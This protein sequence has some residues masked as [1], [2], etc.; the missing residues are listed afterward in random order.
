[1]AMKGDLRVA[2]FTFR[3]ARLQD[4]LAPALAVLC[5]AWS[6][7]VAN[8]YPPWLAAY[9]D[10]LSALGLILLCAAVIQKSASLAIPAISWGCFALAAVPLLQVAFGQVLFFGDGYI[11]FLY[12]LCL[13]T[14]IVVGCNAKKVWRDDFVTFICAAWLFVALLSC[15]ILLMQRFS[16][17]AGDFG[18]FIRDVR[19][20]SAP[21]GN[22]GQPNQ[23]ATFF[24]L[25]LVALTCL[26]ERR[27]VGGRWAMVAAVLIVVCMAMTQSR[28]A[29]L[30]LL[31]LLLL[32]CAYRQRLQL[33]MPRMAV[34]ALIAL[35]MISF[36]VLPSLI[37]SAGLQRGASLASRM[38]AG[39]RTVIWQQLWEATLRQPWLGY[40]WNQVSVAQMNVAADFGTS[41][42]TEHSHNLLLDLA[43]WNGLPIAILLSSCMAWWLVVRARD[44]RSLDALFGLAVIG[45]FLM[46]SMLEFPLDYLYFLIPCGLAIGIVAADSKTSPARAISRPVAACVTL[47]AAGVYASVVIDYLHF[48]GKY[49]DLRFTL[50]R[51]GTPLVL[52][53][54]PPVRTMFTQLA[55]L[56]D[57]PL[58]D[59]RAGMTRDQLAWM[60]DVASRHPY[61]PVL[62]RYA[63]AQ[64]L[65]GHA[66]VAEATFLKMKR[67][68]GDRDYA[69]AKRQFEELVS[70]RYPELKVVRLH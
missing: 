27:L 46:H 55:A 67:L 64:A 50:A 23:M 21:F 33:R 31:V 43:L 29:L 39:P 53:S 20:G 5:F 48:E 14:A 28:A 57:F 63:V 22:L 69:D 41:R 1:M 36:A 38:E 60:G 26:Y 19:P 6:F 25:A 54:D 45:V 61:V 24:A 65:N 37:D 47:V 3:Q 58:I 2:F 18:M 62:Y 16:I 35:W 13:A 12:L 32:L 17:D 49:R 15:L 11:A 10:M 52:A 66:S 30:L 7:L 9:N 56:Y 51:V 34:L 68:H 70:T 44:L 8:H 59:A 40:G 4:V 42:F